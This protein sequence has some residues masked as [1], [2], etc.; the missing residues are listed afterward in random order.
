MLSHKMTFSQRERKEPLLELMRLKHVSKRF[1]NRTWYVIDNAI[2]HEETHTK[3]PQRRL[4]QK[5]SSGTMSTRLLSGPTTK[6][7]TKTCR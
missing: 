5:T 4:T 2:Q 1:R 3:E 6:K 7:S